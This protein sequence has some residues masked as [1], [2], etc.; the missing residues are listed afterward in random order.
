LGGG[1]D[2]EWSDE[3]VARR[4]QPDGERL[5]LVGRTNVATGDPDHPDRD[6]FALARLDHGLVSTFTVTPKPGSHGTLSPA[7]VQ[8]VVHSDHAE[9][10]ALPDAG[11]IVDRIEKGPGYCDGGMDGETF[12][13]ATVMQSCEVR[14]S[15]K[16][17]RVFADSYE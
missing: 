8:Q 12:V 5:L 4:T 17:L 10:V 6:E 9:F 16:R 1:N 7:A 3:D 15:F 14:V 11:Y 2:G 13:S